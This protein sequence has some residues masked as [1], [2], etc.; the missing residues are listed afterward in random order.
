MPRQAD[1]G[2]CDYSS[3]IA[4]RRLVVASTV[5]LSV[6]EAA[7]KLIDDIGCTLA[8]MLVNLSCALVT[9]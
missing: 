9:D 6:L 5:T 7:C 4:T 3:C 2:T 1:S 8:G